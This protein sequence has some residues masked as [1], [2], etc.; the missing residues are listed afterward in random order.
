MSAYATVLKQL[1][2]PD[3]FMP[4][5][6]CF[7]WNTRLIWLHALSDG[8]IFA[9]YLSI[10]FTLIYFARQRR[11][12]PYRRVFW[13][14]GAFIILCGFTHALDVW[15]LWHPDYWVSGSV[16]ALTAVASVA[17]AA[18]VVKLLPYAVAIPFP[19]RPPAAPILRG[20]SERPLLLAYGVA[21]STAAAMLLVI[22]G[23]GP[24]AASD[25]PVIVFVIP[26]LFAAYFGGLVPGL[27]TTALSVLASYYFIL[28]PV[29]AWRVGSPADNVK[30]VTLL[31]AGVCISVMSEKL[32][33]ARAQAQADEARLAGIISSAMDAV[34]TV[35]ERQRVTIFNP[36]AE[37]M[38]GCEAREALGHP[39]DRFI[40]ERFRAAHAEH[41]RSFGRTPTRT[42]GM[43]DVRALSGLRA[44]GEEFPIEASISHTEVGGRQ[45]F[46]AILRD[47][48]ERERAQAALLESEEHYRSLFQN[49]TSG[50]AY[51]E[52]LYDDTSK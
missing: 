21:L 4:H 7:L 10:S 49:M 30:W 28:P 32:L 29:H 15:T 37:R 2:A 16:K 27:V 48:T 20:S 42:R 14:F 44:N 1:L 45:L 47:I 50:F 40:P 52:M 46:T 33:R 19:M 41:L 5:G 13:C 17:A 35:D 22:D 11:D 31:L 51:C 43:G 9:A 24:A 34:I 18:L 6:S 23:A 26:I 8:V 3:G 39:L 36:A 38:F 25:T 12:L